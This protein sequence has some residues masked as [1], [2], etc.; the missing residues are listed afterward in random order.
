MVTARIIS[1]GIGYVC[2]LFLAGY[3]LGK[4]KHVDITKEGSGNVGTTN[5]T[6]ILGVKVGVITL[7]CDILKGL[8]AALIVWLIFRST[9]D[10]STV[11]ILMS[12]ATFG[13]MLGHM[14][15]VYMGFKGGKGVATS[16]G[17]MAVCVPQVL[18]LCILT[19]LAAVL[20]TKYVSLGSILG[21]IV[22]VA[23]LFLYGKGDSLM[24]DGAQLKEV[25]AL[26]CAAAALV[27][28]K[29]HANI[30]RLLRGEENKLNLHK[31]RLKHM[32]ET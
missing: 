32:D 5:A 29:H 1:V 21:V 4:Y 17:F 11:R 6:R 3:L 7:V 24:Y 31:S 13:A 10:R 18:P 16:L 15:P 27:I 19:F 30:G 28:I 2:G 9:Y 23:Q 12:C 22:V 20:L 8:V 25:Y 26:V 14:F